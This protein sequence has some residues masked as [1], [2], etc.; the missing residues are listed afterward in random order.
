MS[1]KRHHQRWALDW[2]WVGLDP[3]YDEFCWFWNG[4]GM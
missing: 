1:V 4:S 2:T 3:D